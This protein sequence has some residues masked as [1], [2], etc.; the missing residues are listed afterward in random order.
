MKC[1]K[2]G[3]EIIQNTCSK[4]DCSCHCMGTWDW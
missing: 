1:E 4:D 3:H 2:C